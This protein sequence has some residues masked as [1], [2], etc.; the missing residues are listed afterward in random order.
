M[1]YCSFGQF[2]TQKTLK[3]TEDT[4]TGRTQALPLHSPQNQRHCER[5]E[6]IRE[7]SLAIMVIME[8]IHL[9]LL[10]FKCRVGFSPPSQRHRL[11]SANIC[12]SISSETRNARNFWRTRKQQ[13]LKLHLSSYQLKHWTIQ[14]T[15]NRITGNDGNDGDDSLASCQLLIDG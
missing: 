7:D 1:L 6:A 11:L 14:K 9:L 2:E 12:G 8:M 13:W 10:L 4:E 5:S 15:L 3:R